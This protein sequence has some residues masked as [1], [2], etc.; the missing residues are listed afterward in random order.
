MSMSSNCLACGKPLGG[1][2]G[3]C[4]SCQQEGETVEDYVI[5][6]DDVIDRIERY[7]IVSS[8]RC[9]NCGDLHT[10]V[11]VDGETFTADSFGIE[12]VEEWQLEM[13]KE[14]DW[15]ENNESA[16]RKALHHLEDEWPESVHA[17]RNAILR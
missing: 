10:S 7:F 11:T 4:Y 12:S 9:A 8:V 13:E 14:E 6:D 3:L 15:L 1:Q 17:C 2:T 5:V 16:V